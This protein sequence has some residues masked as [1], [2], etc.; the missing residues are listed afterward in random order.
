MLGPVAIFIVLASLSPIQDK[1]PPAEKDLEE[2]AKGYLSQDPTTPKGRFE[3][4]RIL[5]R[6][7]EGPP[8]SAAEVKSWTSRLLK[9]ES[10][11]PQLE[12]KSGRHY[13]WTKPEVAEDKGLYIVGGE[14][15]NPKGL[16]IAMHG[17]EA[18]DAWCGPF[19]H[20][21]AAGKL[22][23]LMICRRS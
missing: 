3:Q 17:G 9:L 2:L 20:Q 15:K 4:F 5:K 1:K 21:S 22:D 6:L 14:S 16:L 12:K 13:F 8:L 11:G 7:D 18:R 23:W 19:A 10:K